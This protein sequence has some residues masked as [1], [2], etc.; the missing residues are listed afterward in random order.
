ME[1]IHDQ[2]AY[3]R[4]VTKTELFPAQA[5]EWEM[6]KELRNKNGESQP[7]GHKERRLAVTWKNL[8]VKGV[9]KGSTVLENFAS[10][11]NIPQLLRGN[12]APV[13]LKTILDDSHGC[14]KPGE[15]LLVLGRPGAGCTT[16][17][18]LLAN[19]RHG[20]AEITGD[21]HFGSMTSTDAEGYRGQ[22]V[23]NTE[24]EIFFPF[25][26]VNQTMDF[27]TRMKISK[28]KMGTDPSSY[29]YETVDYLLRSMG[30]K[31]VGDTRVGNEYVRGVSGGER[32][33]VSI[34]EVVATQGIV[35]C[36]DNSTRGLD[37]STA[38]GWAKAMRALTDILGITTIATLYQA[39]NG[40][41][42]QFDKI[43][44]L[45]EGKQ[46]FYGP[47]AKALPYMQQLGF[48]Y[49]NG[50]NIGDYLTSVTIPKERVIEKGYEAR[51]PRNCSELRLAYEKSEI[52]STMETEYVYPTTDRAKAETKE[53]KTAV[54]EE[55]DSPRFL[56]T[57]SF[58]QQII[59]CIKRQYQILW[60]D[61]ATLIIEQLS[62]LVTALMC[63]SVFYNASDDSQGLFSKGGAIFLSLLLFI[64]I[65][66]SEI[67]DSFFGRPVLA[68][69][70]D[71]AFL[72]PAVFCIAQVVTDIPFQLF[73][74]AIFSL[75]LYWMVGLKH[76]AAAF[77]TYYVN[78]YAA[79]MNA[80]AMFRLVGAAFATIDAA[81]KVGG[82]LISVSLTYIGYM[83]PKPEMKNWFVWMFWINP[84]AYAFEA[85]L[86]NEFK[87]TNIQCVGANLIPTGP[88]YTELQYSSCAGIP[89]APRGATSLTGEQYLE[90]LSYASSRIWRNFG[91]VLAWWAL[92]VAGTI[93]FTCKWQIHGSGGGTLLVPREL[94]KDISTKSPSDPEAQTS[95][96]NGTTLP[97][98][99]SAENTTWD[100]KEN[101]QTLIRN[102]SILTWKGFSYTV[103]TPSGE[104]HLLDNV[105]GWV[106]PGTL[107]ALMV[108][109]FHVS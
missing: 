84:Q 80:T 46:V 11:Y 60:S 51:F 56:Y 22:V 43:L 34:V 16:L 3:E 57:V 81:A 33:R 24:D 9:G 49:K 97:Y 76:T 54:S 32:K 83:I 19:K 71:F 67:T 31:H 109:S 14:V 52:K 88:G 6:A 55:K 106:K 42:N 75:P 104:R 39:G 18:K 15:M 90:S 63:G 58:A 65:A 68:K 26:T 101:R 30:I 50:A 29:Q 98:D 108:S 85:L 69:H 36:W 94:K 64:M 41:F 1:T 53:F 100:G 103:N 27:A 89:G 35:F 44:V 91:I 105:Q 21:V 13:P 72:H 17:L 99:S 7:D 10:Q 62:V 59:T 48:V 107:V 40:I 86:G 95:G 37:A 70:K 87:D 8:T 66:M 20:F 5:S 96:T 4:E 2:E 25:L 61:K 82:F 79:F 38:L 102:T 73:S 92:Y 12:R 47:R 23:M 93:F 78:V 28:Q 74:V 77:F 45:D